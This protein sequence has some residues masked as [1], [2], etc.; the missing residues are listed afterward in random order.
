M[1]AEIPFCRYFENTDYAKLALGYYIEYYDN[2]LLR[3][4]KKSADD[5]LKTIPKAA[6]RV[7][8]TEIDNKKLQETYVAKNKLEKY[9]NENLKEAEAESRKEYIEDELVTIIKEIDYKIEKAINAYEG[10]E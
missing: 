1:Y 6:R 4:V 9:L 7:L 2:E 5:Y 10:T 8:K 3:E